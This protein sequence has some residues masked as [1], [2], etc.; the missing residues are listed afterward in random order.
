MGVGDWLNKLSEIYFDA[1]KYGYKQIKLLSNNDTINHGY[2]EIAN[3]Y[4]NNPPCKVEYE[5]CRIKGNISGKN[6]YLY[7][8]Q[9]WPVKKRYQGGN[10]VVVY[11]CICNPLYLRSNSTKCFTE[12][13]ADLLYQKLDYEGIDYVCLED[14]EI[15][16][17]NPHHRNR[18]KR[19]RSDEEFVEYLFDT[20]ANCKYYIGSECFY[21]HLCKAMGVPFVCLDKRTHRNNF[22]YYFSDN[23]NTKAY[24]RADLLISSINYEYRHL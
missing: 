20:L 18:P 22:K 10:R 15:E 9:Y 13:E 17:R 4:F 1:E 23:V 21:T 6:D 7:Q 19:L 11:V 3:S 24:D 12:L 5:Y 14:H 16:H 2:I 8:G